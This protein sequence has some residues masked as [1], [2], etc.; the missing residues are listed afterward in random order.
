[1]AQLTIK[2][3]H[4]DAVKLLIETEVARTTTMIL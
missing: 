4:P 1:M 3:D 2:C